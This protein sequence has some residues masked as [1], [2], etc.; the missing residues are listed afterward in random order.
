KRETLRSG[1]QRRSIRSRQRDAMIGWNDGDI[2]QSGELPDEIGLRVHQRAGVLVC[3]LEIADLLVD[4]GDLR[5]QRIYLTDRLNDVLVKIAALGL[6]VVRGGVEVGGQLAGRGQHALPQFQIRR[7]GGELL[8]TVK[9]TADVSADA[10]SGTRELGLKLLQLP[11]RG[12]EL[13]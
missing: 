3:I 6:K 10:G 11:Q 13:A 5:G 12:V 2:H 7:I 9:E 8:Q 4:T 1:D